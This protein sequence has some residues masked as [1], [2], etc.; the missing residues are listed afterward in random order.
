MAVRA[1]LTMTVAPRDARAFEEAWVGASSYA[2]DHPECIRQSL[3][4]EDGDP[5][6]FVITSDWRDRDAFHSFERGAGQDA[7]T[8]AL[9]RLRTSTVMKLTEIVRH[10]E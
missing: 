1:Y 4:R 8:A 5:V 7:A 9:R 2:A 3:T 6:L 10:V